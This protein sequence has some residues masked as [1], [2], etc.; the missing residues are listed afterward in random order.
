MSRIRVTLKNSPIQRPGTQRR[1]LKALG[2]Y[3][4]H[5]SVEHNDSP[6]L[7]GQLAKV[8][9]LVEWQVVEEA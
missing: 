1:T 2:L 9:H 3:K 6:G 5:Q 4:L 7:R 8:S